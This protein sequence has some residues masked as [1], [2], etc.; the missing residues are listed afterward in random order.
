MLSLGS[1]T[2]EHQQK[3][4]TILTEYYSGVGREERKGG[5]ERGRESKAGTVTTYKQ[6]KDKMFCSSCMYRDQAGHTWIPGV[7]RDVVLAPYQIYLQ[8]LPV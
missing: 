8:V 3:I 6:S 2:A 1:N 5:K 7:S 4:W